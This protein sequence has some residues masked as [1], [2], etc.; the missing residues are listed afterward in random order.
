MTLILGSV[1]KPTRLLT[2]ENPARCRRSWSTS[3][4]C[5]GLVLSSFGTDLRVDRFIHRRSLLEKLAQDPL[6]HRLRPEQFEANAAWR[7][8]LDDDAGRHHQKP[9]QGAS[10]GQTA[11]F[12]FSVEEVRP[13]DNQA[14]AITLAAPQNPAFVHIALPD[15][16]PNPGM[17]R[18]KSLGSILL[19]P[20]SES[21]ILTHGELSD[22]RIGAEAS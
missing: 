6:S 5:H 21:S 8:S 19:Q 18:V 20:E 12:R 13:N 14:H 17:P 11:N 4:R 16:V 7:K 15:N 3:Y 1:I 9:S 10:D 2:C 22:S